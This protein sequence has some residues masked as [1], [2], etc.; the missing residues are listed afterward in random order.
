M[1]ASCVRGIL[2]LRELAPIGTPSPVLADYLSTNFGKWIRGF[3]TMRGSDFPVIDWGAKLGL[4]QAKHGRQSYIVAVEIETAG[5]PR[6]AGFIADHICEVVQARHRDFHLGK[7]RLTGRPRW[8]LDRDS[9]LA[10]DYPL[11]PSKACSISRCASGLST[12]RGRRG[13]PP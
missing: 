7:L 8:V 9:L 10:G 12:V 5:G 1:E 3:A 11:I 4:P 2:P 6:L 13:G